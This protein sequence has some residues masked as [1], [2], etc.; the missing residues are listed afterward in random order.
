MDCLPERCLI[1]LG[2]QLF[3]SLEVQHRI[4]ISTDNVNELPRF[5]TQFV[6][7]LFQDKRMPAEASFYFSHLRSSARRKVRCTGTR[8][9]DILLLLARTFIFT[10]SSSS[11]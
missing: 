4:L 8:N 9:D 5:S 7:M 6:E 1:Q 2:N 10:F 11:E 3:W